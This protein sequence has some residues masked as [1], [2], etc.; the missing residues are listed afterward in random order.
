MSAEYEQMQEQNN[1]EKEHEAKSNIELFR[2]KSNFRRVILACAL[3][4]ATQMT[5]VYL[6]CVVLV[7]SKIFKPV[8]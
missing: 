7:H 5:G 6:K 4:A 2:K 8:T 1:Y 3:Q